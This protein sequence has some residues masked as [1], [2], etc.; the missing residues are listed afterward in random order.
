MFSL[1]LLIIYLS[2]VSLGLPDAVLGA[3]WPIIHEEFGVPISFSGSIYMLISCCTILSSLK[4]ESLRLRFGTGKITAF[5]VLLTAVAIFGFSIS[6]SLSVMLFFAIPYGLG[7]GSVDAALNHYVA[8][9][10]SGRSMN[11]LH[12]M[13]GIG[14]ALGPY[15]L[16]FVLQR[17]ESWRSGYLVLSMIQA[18]LTIILFLSL[19][20]WGKEEKKEKTEEKKTPMS[21]RQILSITGAKECLVSFFLYCAIEQTLGLW[22]GSFMVYSLKIEAKLAASFVALF[23]FGITFGRFLAG[24]LAAKWQD[25]ALILGG[26]GILFLGLVLLFCSMVPGQEVKLFGMELR[27]LL[28]ICALLLSGLG[29]AP[30]YPAIIHS[31]PRNFGAENTSALIGK[32][33][34]AAYIGSM[35][36]P[37]FFGVLAKIFGT[38]LFPFF[39][40]VLF[41][42]ML[43]MY[44]NLLYKT[45]GKRGKIER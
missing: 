3:A 9:H 38:G 15:I 36:F 2:F 41:F 32:Q 14:A 34:A 43:F 10:Y 21:F 40:T 1:L 13:W 45:R 39:S 18:T 27:Q 23:Y 26:C 4:S 19:G 35:S 22:S 44:R 8:V 5:S 37:P 31:T 6:P 16:G 24:I 33:M 28:V 29:C 11:W 17:G 7:A 30:I 25:E 42:G 12:C 20:L